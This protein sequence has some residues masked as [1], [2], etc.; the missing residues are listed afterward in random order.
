MF[1]SDLWLIFFSRLF[2]DWN[3]GPLTD[4]FLLSLSLK[5]CCWGINV[6][7]SYPSLW[8]ISI[9]W[10]NLSKPHELHLSFKIVVSLSR[11]FPRVVSFISGFS[12]SFGIY[13]LNCIICFFG[14]PQHLSSYFCIYFSF[15]FFSWPGILLTDVPILCVS[16]II[17]SCLSEVPTWLIKLSIPENSSL[18]GTGDNWFG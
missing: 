5:C 14:A 1:R 18:F 12:S 4:S 3:Y 15:T 10:L 11:Y 17:V 2:F 7:W 13:L 6:T 16:L 8:Y 9:E